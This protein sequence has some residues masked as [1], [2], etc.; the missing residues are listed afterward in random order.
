MIFSSKPGRL[1]L[2]A[3]LVGALALVACGCGRKT[4]V[5]RPPR[6]PRPPLDIVVRNSE[7]VQEDESGRA[8]WKIV[9]R[10]IRAS[11]R[12]LTLRVQGAS[13]IVFA[14]SGSDRIRLT[15]PSLVASGKSK[16]LEASG[17]VSV[18]SPEKEISFR[19]GRLEVDLPSDRVTA[20]GGIRGS[21][22]KGGFEAGS[23]ESDLKFDEVRLGGSGGVR[24][25]IFAGG[26]QP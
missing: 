15:C 23:L 4:S 16:R 7:T 21:S 12:D 8:L 20:S 25:T 13:V 1:R 14:P 11:E 9:A 10:E 19:A 17:G 26:L 3:A 18:V 22:P 24:A 6:P 5:E 2:T